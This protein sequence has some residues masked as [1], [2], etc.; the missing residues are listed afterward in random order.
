MVSSGSVNSVGYRNVRVA[1][2]V[3]AQAFVLVQDQ[4][5]YGDLLATA[6]AQRA[7][8]GRVG[9]AGDVDVFPQAGLA[10]APRSGE[11]AVEKALDDPWMSADRPAAIAVAPPGVVLEIGMMPTPR[12]LL[13]PWRCR[14]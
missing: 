7:D 2:A 10:V 5:A 11:D 9:S 14:T 8:D 4:G 6:V 3:A 13:P 12:G 1:P